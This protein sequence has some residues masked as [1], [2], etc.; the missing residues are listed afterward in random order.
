MQLCP[1]S[2]ICYWVTQNQRKGEKKMYQKEPQN[3][4]DDLIYCDDW[5]PSDR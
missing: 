1:A 5:F 4:V 3:D 2:R